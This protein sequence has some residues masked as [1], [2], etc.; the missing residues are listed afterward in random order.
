MA[1]NQPQGSPAPLTLIENARVFTPFPC[2][3]S[4]LLLAGSRIV[5]MGRDPG[6]IR[7]PCPVERLDAAGRWLIP[8]LVDPLAHII[9]GGGEGGF[10]FRTPELYADEAIRAGVTT[11][12]AA[13]GTD[14]ITRNLPQLLGKV[15]ELQAAGLSAYM[16]TGSY[17]L[18]AKTL[19][20]SVE[21]DLMLLPDIIGVGEIAISDHRSSMP[22]HQVLAETVAQ[23]RVGGLLA[24]KQGV[25]LFHLGDGREGLTPLRRLVEQTDLPRRQLYPTHCNRSRPL[26][27]EAIAWGRDGGYIDFTTSTLPQLLDD[28]ELDAAEALVLCLRQGVAPDRI[29]FSSDANASL[30]R[31]DAE[32]RLLG[33][34]AGRIDSIWQQ[35]VLAMTR[36]GLSPEQVLPVVTRNPA[37]ILGLNRKGRL[38]VGQDADLLLVDPDT[39]NIAATFAMGRRLWHRPDPD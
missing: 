11:L 12:V 33:L 26:L 37:D 24:G 28:G 23:A 15:R 30:P 6:D 19:S 39:L 8:G 27:Q 36:E 31:F 16:Y 35:A 32:G 9:G 1:T 21:Q 3:H 18:P 13:L 20:G 17:H 29:S 7:L 14:S 34:E 25:A 5:W 38:A 4:A 10:G 2:E 22:S